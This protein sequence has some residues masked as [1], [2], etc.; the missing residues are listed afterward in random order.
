MPSEVGHYIYIPSSIAVGSTTYSISPTDQSGSLFQTS[1]SLMVVQH[2]SI[3]STLTII[4]Y[5]SMQSSNYTMH[6]TQYPHFHYLISCHFG[7]CGEDGRE[8]LF[9]IPPVQQ[10]MKVN[11]R[12]QV[13]HT[14]AYRGHAHNRVDYR[15]VLQ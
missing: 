9:I 2:T 13:S 3:L 4:H 1:C 10:P 6:P 8:T 15:T 7:D 14:W 12:E 5:A 11:C